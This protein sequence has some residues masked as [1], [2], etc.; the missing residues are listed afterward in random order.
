M[1]S[2]PS[3]CRSMAIFAGH[4]LRDFKRAPALL[5]R[6]RESVTRQAFWCIF[7]FRAEFQNASHAFANLSGQRL[8]SAAVFVLDDPGRVFV[9]QDPAAG[10]RLHA[11]MATRGR[12]GAR[13]NVFPRL[14]LRRI[15]EE[16][17]QD[18]G[19]EN[20]PSDG[21]NQ[22]VAHSECRRTCL[23]ISFARMGSQRLALSF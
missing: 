14:I 19:A 16:W 1:R 6:S 18:R 4:T 9:L 21:G 11:A 3:G 17:R 10:N 23:L 12:T 15:Q 7:G 2:Q 22:R 8:I 5:R 20:Q 13:A